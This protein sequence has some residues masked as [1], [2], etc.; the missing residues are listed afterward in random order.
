MAR[1]TLDTPLTT[2]ADIEGSDAAAVDAAMAVADIMYTATVVKGIRLTPDARAEVGRLFGPRLGSFLKEAVS[3][4]D[5]RGVWDSPDFRGVRDFV[6]ATVIDPI[7]DR[8]Q[9]ST[10]PGQ[11]TPEITA[12]SLRL[13]AQDVMTSPATLLGCLAAVRSWTDTI[14]VDWRVIGG[15]CSRA[16]DFS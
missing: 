3:L 4:N 2:M 10:P 16:F 11:P 12:E 14:G 8:V 9:G 1:A 7:A 13:A 5:G 6:L 15:V